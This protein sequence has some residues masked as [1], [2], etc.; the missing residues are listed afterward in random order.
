MPSKLKKTLATAVAVIVVA[1]GFL[2]LSGGSNGGSRVA[3]PCGERIMIVDLSSESRAPRLVAQ[4]E[5]IASVAA[6]SAVVCG[7]SFAV[8]GVAGGGEVLPIIDTDQLDAYAPT[9]PNEQVRSSRFTSKDQNQVGQL[10]T[11]SLQKAWNTTHSKTTSV[12]ALYATAASYS[13]SKTALVIMTA[14]VN[15]D[16]TLNMNRPLDPGAGKAA[17]DRLTVT[18]FRS[19]SVTVVGVAQMDSTLPPPSSIWPTE[20]ESFNQTLCQLSTAAPC[21]LFPAASVTQ[22]LI[23]NSNPNNT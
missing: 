6:V 8:Y 3:V 5:S 10:V 21:R 14:G 11:S 12:E 17:A 22:A 20:I 9:G 7:T 16:S 1:A 4:T 13:T 2:L 23:P 18:Q 15:I 19:R